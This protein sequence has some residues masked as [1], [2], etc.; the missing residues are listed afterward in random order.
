MPI[1]NKE[2]RVENRKSRDSCTFQKNF[3]SLWCT[4]RSM[5]IFDESV[6][7]FYPCSEIWKI[8]L[9]RGSIHTRHLVLVYSI[10]LGILFVPHADTGVR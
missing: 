4:L 7:S 5:D 3:L 9:V 1:I 2:L 6:F 10:C 8:S